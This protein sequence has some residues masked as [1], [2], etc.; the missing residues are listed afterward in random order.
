MRRAGETRSASGYHTRP[1]RAS[2]CRVGQAVAEDPLGAGRPSLLLTNRPD[3]CTAQYWRAS[4]C[5]RLDRKFRN[6]FNKSHSTNRQLPL[7]HEVWA[8]MKGA[9]M[10]RF[11]W[12]GALGLIATLGSSSGANAQECCGDCSGDMT[13]AINELVTCV[14]IALGSAEVSTCQACDCD[15]TGSVEINDLIKAVNVALGATTCGGTGAICGNNVT[16]APETCDDGNTFGGDGCAANCTAEDE[17]VSTFDT[18]KTL[19]FVQTETGLIPPAGLHLTGSQVLRY[20]PAALRRHDGCQRPAVQGGRDSG[21]DQGQRGPFRT[22][23]SA[24]CHLRLCARR[25]GAG[26]L[27]ARHLRSRA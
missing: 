20:R 6:D 21:G 15:A 26:A 8:T 17:R 25:S 19:S 22:S 18:E 3:C 24:G 4:R 9:S 27:R 1:C 14:N 7:G 23:S 10:K 11:V 12:L 2:C 16:E 13:V 5:E